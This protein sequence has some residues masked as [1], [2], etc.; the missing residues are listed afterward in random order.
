MQYITYLA[1][2]YGQGAYNSSTYQ[3]GGTGSVSS[4]GLLTNTGFDILLIVTLACSLAFL[5][6]LV[7]FWRRP[8]KRTQNPS[9]H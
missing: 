5:A 7:R 6:L 2:V 1:T 4:G 9:A 3:D 8:A